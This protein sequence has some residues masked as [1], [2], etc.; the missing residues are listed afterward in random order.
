MDSYKV[1]TLFPSEENIP[2]IVDSFIR[3]HPATSWFHKQAIN[4]CHLSPKHF[5]PFCMVVGE[6]ETIKG[7]ITAIHIQF[8]GDQP[9]T[10]FNSRIQVNGS[11]LLTQENLYF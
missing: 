6:N 9:S 11:P 10:E 4:G 3:N 5:T 2:E 1:K 8:N 7:S